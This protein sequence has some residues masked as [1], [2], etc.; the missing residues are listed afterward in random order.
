MEQL[1][2]AL[3]ATGTTVANGFV[4]F[5]QFAASPVTL[6]VVVTLLSLAWLAGIEVEELTRQGTKPSV[7]LH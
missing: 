5:F 1:T 3:S 2:L 6:S 4:S 7:Q